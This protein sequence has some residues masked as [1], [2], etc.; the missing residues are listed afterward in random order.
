LIETI[1]GIAMAILV[2]FVP[3]LMHFDNP[4]QQDK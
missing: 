1:V 4:R 3:K 2:S